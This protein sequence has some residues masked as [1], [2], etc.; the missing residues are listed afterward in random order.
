MFWHNFSY[1]PAQYPG[2]SICNTLGEQAPS[3]Q[4]WDVCTAVCRDCCNSGAEIPLQ[5]LLLMC[6]SLVFSVGV[7]C[8]LFVFW[9]FYNFITTRFSLLF[10]SPFP[11][12]S[13]KFNPTK[14]SQTTHCTKHW[15]SLVSETEQ[16]FL[17]VFTFSA[18]V[19]SKW[20]IHMFTF[21]WS[22]FGITFFWNLGVLHHLPVGLFYPHHFWN[23]YSALTV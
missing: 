20:C 17:T 7:F 2:G 1:C 18:K 14:H 9:D 15:H 19:L 16:L 11:A 22:C 13:L 4:A 10:S 3:H 8:V 12:P 6:L 21:Y 5:A 23:R